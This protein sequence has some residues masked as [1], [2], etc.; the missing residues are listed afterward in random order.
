MDIVSHDVR[1]FFGLLL[2]KNGYVL[3]QLFSPLIVHTTPE[4]DELKEIAALAAIPWAN[5]GDH[6]TSLASLL[7]VCGDAVE[8]VPEGIAAPGEAV[9][10]RLSRAAHRHSPHADRRS[11][12]EP[13]HAKR[14]VPAALHR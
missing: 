1:K 3:E 2:K 5:G 12:G 8:S 7:R 4:H 10:L 14:R 6:Q 11:G 9:A 13:G